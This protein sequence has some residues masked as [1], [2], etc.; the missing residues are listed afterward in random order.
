MKTRNKGLAFF[1]VTGLNLALVVITFLG[2]IAP[3]VEV[4]FF[5][6][7]QLIP[8]FLTFLIPLHII[9]FI[10]YFKKSFRWMAVSLA[11]IFCCG[12]VAMKDI[13]FSGEPSE[14]PE[15]FSVMS[16]NV[17]T[18]DFK[19]DRIDTVASLIR[20][21][22]PDVISMQE[23]RN[24]KLDGGG[25]SVDYLKKKLNMPYAKFVHLPHHLHGA[26]IFSRYPI[27][28]MDTFYLPRAEIN[29]GLLATVKAPMGN[30]GVGNI[31]LSSFQ[32]AQTLQSE[33]K[34]KEKVTAVHRR[35]GMVLPWQQQKVDQI[36]KKAESYPYPVII[37]GDFNAAPHTRIHQQFKKRFRD[38]FAVAGKGVG[39]TYPL[40]GPLGV[41]IDYQ[42][43]SSELEVVNHQ[44]I[45]SEVSDHYPI[46]VTY[47]LVP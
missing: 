47:H 18:F 9:A 14:S 27:V 4:R 8:A 12:W 37:A 36:L 13:H 7:I 15:G 42:Y 30:I 1:L 41:R 33:E 46:M 20:T 34:L 44:V 11:A 23:F 19:P 43:V 38:S 31:H 16:F 26:V 6:W 17:G 5:S 10:Y 24:Y 39:W 2:L 35:V 3:W 25:Y 29:S 28:K 32:V 22:D 45:S 40:A 21:M